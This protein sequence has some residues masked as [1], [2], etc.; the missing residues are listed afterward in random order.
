MQSPFV[1]VVVEL[2]LPT[3]MW[4]TV[5]SGV[6]DGAVAGFAA[7]LSGSLHGVLALCCLASGCS[8]ATGSTGEQITI[9][10]GSGAPTPDRLELDWMGGLGYIFRDR[11]VPAEGSLVASGDTLA[12]VRIELTRLQDSTRR[13]AVRGILRDIQVSEGAATDEITIGE[14]RTMTV[15][16]APQAPATDGGAQPDDGASEDSLPAQADGGAEA[17]DGP[18]DTPDSSVDGA[19]LD[20]P[21]DSPPTDGMP[22]TDRVLSPIADAYV[23]QGSPGMNFGAST[24]LLVKTQ[25]G[26]TNNRIAYLKF[27]LGAAA[28]PVQRATLRLYGNSTTANSNDGALAVADTSWTETG[29]TWGNKP[30]AGA[31]L[32]AVVVAPALRYYEWDVTAYVKSQQTGGAGVVSLAVTMD[33]SAARPPDAFNSR[34]AADHPPQLVVTQ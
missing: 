12:V 17:K 10:N 20:G 1:P 29:I 23:Q 2:S 8:R 6:H 26:S 9:L 4:C 30:P 25:N 32:A 11:R 3:A 31:H 13:L 27:S 24:S 28:A 5:R 16:L 7:T 33:S 18:I 21:I 15:T 34:E 19:R 22:T 14:W